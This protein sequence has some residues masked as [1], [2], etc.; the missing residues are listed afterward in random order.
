MTGPTAIDEFL[1]R[2]Y[3][4][5]RQLTFHIDELRNRLSSFYVALAGVTG[6]G[7][8]VAA[9][10]SESGTNVAQPGGI[11]LILLATVGLI[12]GFILARLRSVQLE[13]FRIMNNIRARFLE[14]NP[15]LWNVVELSVD[16]LPEPRMTSGTFGWTVMIAL[17]TSSILATGVTLLRPHQCLCPAIVGAAALFVVMV[18]MHLFFARPP[19]PRSYEESSLSRLTGPR[20]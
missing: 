14:H 20:T 9:T 18:V 3:E 10:A 1:F 16:T 6:T 12:I 5:A 13:H 8:G 15:E 17:A 19:K 7:L 4:S 2:E 11:F